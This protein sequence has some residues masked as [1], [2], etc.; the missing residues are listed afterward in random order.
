MDREHKPIPPKHRGVKTSR[1]WKIRTKF[2]E[3]WKTSGPK[4]KQHFAQTLWHKELAGL[5]EGDL[6]RVYQGPL[7]HATTIEVLW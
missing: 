7:Q 1:G 4:L 5:E 2:G 3:V 6:G